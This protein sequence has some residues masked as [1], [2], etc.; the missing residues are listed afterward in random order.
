[1]DAIAKAKKLICESRARFTDKKVILL[2]QW[3]LIYYYLTQ[4]NLTAIAKANKLF[5]SESCVDTFSNLRLKVAKLFCQWSVGVTRMTIIAPNTEYL[6]P[7]NKIAVS[8]ITLVLPR[9]EKLH[10]KINR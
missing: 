7:R 6:I 2:W 3:Q 9:L 4:P 1:M 8:I 5:V 10:I